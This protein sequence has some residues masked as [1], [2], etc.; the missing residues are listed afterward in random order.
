MVVVSKEVK[1]HMYDDYV[2]VCIVIG[3]GIWFLRSVNNRYDPTA[4]IYTSRAWIHGGWCITL[5]RTIDNSALHQNRRT[6]HLIG[7]T[8]PPCSPPY[9]GLPLLPYLYIIY[10]FFFLLKFHFILLLIIKSQIHFSA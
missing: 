8:Y 4:K 3:K 7:P 6:F 10:N 5:P 2:F 9:L 1:R